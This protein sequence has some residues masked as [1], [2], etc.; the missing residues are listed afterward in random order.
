MYR[1]VT[2]WLATEGTGYQYHYEQLTS[3]VMSCSVLL[4]LPP[5]YQ[6]NEIQVPYHNFNSGPPL[7]MN[8]KAALSIMAKLW[9]FE[10]CIFF[11]RTT[12]LANRASF[13]M[14]PLTFKTALP[15]ACNLDKE[16]FQWRIWCML[17]RQ[18]PFL[19]KIMAISGWHSI[20]VTWNKASKSS[21]FFNAHIATQGDS[22]WV[23]KK[24]G[25]INIWAAVA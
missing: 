15:L 19:G 23:L 17:D 6:E 20:A 16:T 11:K 10:V 24:Q 13:Y 12:H 14:K 9:Q 4:C 22:W 1:Q 2:C 7:G 21:L 18:I 8:P 5:C 25:K 3:S